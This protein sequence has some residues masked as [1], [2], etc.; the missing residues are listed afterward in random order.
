MGLRARGTG[1]ANVSSFVD[2]ERVLY[3]PGNRGDLSGVSL[4]GG[5]DSFELRID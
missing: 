2:E 4:I 1:S 3:S 5:W